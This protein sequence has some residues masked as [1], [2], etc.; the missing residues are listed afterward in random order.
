MTLNHGRTQ[1]SMPSRRSEPP[2]KPLDPTKPGPVLRES[3][4]TC[5][6]P[7]EYRVASSTGF[8]AQR[9]AV[10]LTQQPSGLGGVLA[11]K[12]RG[13]FANP[14]LGPGSRHPLELVDQTIDF[15]EGTQDQ[16]R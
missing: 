5:R 10:G 4:T 8:A 3:L 2:N 11:T 6:T 9:S 14:T 1:E 12:Q 16:C 7:L 15:T 13:D